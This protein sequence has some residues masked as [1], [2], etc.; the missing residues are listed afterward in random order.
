MF[1]LEITDEKNSIDFI[2]VA[3]T[4]RGYLV[5]GVEH[6]VVNWGPVNVHPV[7]F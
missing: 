3:N 5:A 6:I 1:F 2:V 7:G 4:L